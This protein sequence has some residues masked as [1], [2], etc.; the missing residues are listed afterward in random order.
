MKAMFKKLMAVAMAGALAVSMLVGCAGSN[1]VAKKSVL[2]LLNKNL[3]DSKAT[4]RV[5]EDS[6]MDAVAEKVAAQY[7]IKNGSIEL[8]ENADIDKILKDG[9]DTA[10]YA[11]VTWA[12]GKNYVELKDGKITTTQASGISKKGEDLQGQKVG[13]KVATVTGKDNAGKDAKTTILV[14]VKKA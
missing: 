12:E 7:E 10:K 11:I 3:V 2:E 5:E 8:K 6:K 9:G 1:E 14:I 4:T 13:I